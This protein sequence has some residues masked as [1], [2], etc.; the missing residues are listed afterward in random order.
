VAL[1]DGCGNV[2]KRC[3]DSVFRLERQ[4]GGTTVGGAQFGFIP[5]SISMRFRVPI[6]ASAAP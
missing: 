4:R 1:G 2:R 6:F 5:A 3:G